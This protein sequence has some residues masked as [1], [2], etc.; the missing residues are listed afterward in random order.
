MLKNIQKSHKIIAWFSAGITSAIAC[1]LAIEKY[2]KNNIELCY[3]KI[4][5]SHSD[6]ERFI[7]DCENWYGMKINI[8]Q[9]S[10]LRF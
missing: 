9:R 1:K 6:N 7:K 8:F 4:D 2:G 3:I 10:N 5:S